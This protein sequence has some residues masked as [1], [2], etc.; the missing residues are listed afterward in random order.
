[1]VI[2]LFNLGQMGSDPTNIPTSQKEAA[3]Y[4]RRFAVI[5][6]YHPNH[7]TVPIVGAMLDQ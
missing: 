1:M 6:M 2:P 7:L 3:H 5:F 4:M